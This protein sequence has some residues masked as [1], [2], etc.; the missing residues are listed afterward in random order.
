MHDLAVGVDPDGADAWLWQDCYVDGATVGAPPDEF[1]TQG[2]AWGLAA[3]DPWRTQQA[4]YAPFVETLRASLRAGGGLRVDH[5]MGLFRLFWI[6]AGAEPGDG[7]YVRYPAAD[8][9]DILALE[10][11]R[12]GA[13]VVGEDLGTVEAGVREELARRRVLCYRLLWFEDRD[14]SAFPRPAMAAVTTHD[15][16]TVAGLWTGRDL[17][18]ERRLGRRPDEEANAGIRRR[19]QE[20]TGL[21]DGAEVDDVVVAAYAALGRAPST[22]LV[23]SLDDAVCSEDR[24]NMPG[25][26]DWPSWSLALPASLEALESHPMPRRLAGALARGRS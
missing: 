15:L 14:P 1:N 25:R 5:V 19:L 23:A 21:G 10:A 13:Y 26:N 24:P 11:H 3:P 7:A 2:Q 17:E 12:A 8:L 16:P 20:L 22:L 9:L 4:A 6:P 18:H